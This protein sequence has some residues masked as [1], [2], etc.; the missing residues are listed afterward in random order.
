MVC[1]AALSAQERMEREKEFAYCA[2]T[3]V[4]AA[5]VGS[6]LAVAHVGD[7]RAALGRRRAEGGAAGAGASAI[8]ASFLT[9]DH[10]PNSPAESARSAG[11]GG[12]IVYLHGGKP[13]LRGGDFS[14]AQAQGRKPMQLNYSRAFGG[15]RLKPYGL[16]AAPDV[17][18]VELS[19]A[20]HTIL[21]LGSDGLWDIFSDPGEACRR[22]WEAHCNG[23]DPSAILSDAALA[24]H[25]ARGTEDNVTCIV[26]IL[27]PTA[28]GGAVGGAAGSAASASGP[29]AGSAAA[30]SGSAQP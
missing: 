17:I 12:S 27:A 15:L 9:L 29:L 30:S 16:S 3:A 4:A 2:S 11:A 7:S 28:A 5:L 6:T 13:F 10:K 23:W 8:E 26:L 20:E 21:I 25:E 1:S 24:G 18:S 22:A 19:A 14:A